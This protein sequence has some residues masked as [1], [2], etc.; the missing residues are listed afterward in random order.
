MILFYETNTCF[1][2]SKG[3]A[4]TLG[5][6]HANS[7]WG[8][9]SWCSVTLKGTCGIVRIAGDTYACGAAMLSGKLGQFLDIP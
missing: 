8:P 9:L 2:S 1:G 7:H 4:I 5:T 3:K 6:K